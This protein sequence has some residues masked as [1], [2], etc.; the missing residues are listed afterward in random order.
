MIS[1]ENM[2]RI[3]I[4]TPKLMPL[5]TGSFKVVKRI[6]PTAY[7]L[8]LAPRPKMKMHNMFHVSLVN[9]RNSEEHGVI[10]IPPT[11]TLGEQQ[12]FEVHRI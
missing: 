2:K 9:F 3:G 10:P 6:Q 12:V 4:G 5:W 1:T 11:L 7:E 8:E